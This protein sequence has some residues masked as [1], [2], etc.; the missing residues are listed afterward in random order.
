MQEVDCPA[1]VKK[2]L[3]KVFEESL[4]TTVPD[5]PDVVPSIDPCAANKAGIKFADYQWLGIYSETKLI[6]LLFCISPY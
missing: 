5:E 6:P 1:S 4:R 2:Q 3:A